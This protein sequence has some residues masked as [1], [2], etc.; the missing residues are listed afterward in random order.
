MLALFGEQLQKEDFDSKTYL[1]GLI[2]QS[3]DK[4]VVPTEEEL[5]NFYPTTEAQETSEERFW[6]QDLKEGMFLKD[7]LFE[8][9]QE[10]FCHG[11][12]Y[13]ETQLTSGEK[14]SH[15]LELSLEDWT[16]FTEILAMREKQNWNL[17]SPFASF[18]IKLHQTNFRATLL[19][20]SVSPEGVSKL[21]LR[22]LNSEKRNP[23]DYGE[24][25]EL[26]LE[27]FKKQE[28]VLIAGSTG[29][30]KTS[31]LTSLLHYQKE[32]DHLIILEDTFEI[33][34]NHSSTTRLLA[35]EKNPN[36]TLK[37]YMSYAMRMSPQRLIIG[38]LRGAETV[39]YMLAM[40]TGHKGLMSTVHAS[41]AYD[42]LSRLAMLFGLYSD[43][44]QINYSQVLQLI[45]RNIG[46]VVFLEDKKVKEVIK[47]LGSENGQAFY[48]TL[49]I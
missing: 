42:A 44:Q 47:V 17:S 18:Y 21:F 31:F 48:E 36:K 46:Y 20:K 9:L 32:N 35:E 33:M 13:L 7:F 41:S 19:H 4:G 14:K 22:R 27:L 16:L 28:N 10:I 39:P 1:R 30:G 6:Y 5:F 45:C 26:V 8:N 25:G 38:E 43:G 11:S 12:D 49:A 15:V 37:A 29:S 34:L 40:N 2:R 3:L 23:T 24:G